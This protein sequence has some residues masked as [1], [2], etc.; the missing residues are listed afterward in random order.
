M[1]SLIEFESVLIG[2][3]IRDERYFAAIHKHMD[4]SFF[5]NA[6]Y[7]LTF[8]N[9]KNFYDKYERIPSAPEVALLNGRSGMSSLLEIVEETTGYD[10][11]GD[12]ILYEKTKTFLQEKNSMKALIEANSDY[13]ERKLDYGKVLARF[14]EIANIG[15]H[16]DF[17]IEL[18]AD[19]KKI[20]T[21]LRAEDKRIKTGWAWLDKALRGGWRADGKKL[22]L[23]QGAANVG[24]SIWLGNV[25]TN[26]CRQGKN[27]L[28]LSFEM[29]EV[30]YAERLLSDLTK[31]KIGELKNQGEGVISNRM[32]SLK[33]NTNIGSLYVKEFPPSSITVADIKVFITKLIASGRHIDAIVVDYIGLI[34]GK[35]GD[36]SYAKG[37]DVAEKL[38]ALSYVF[39][40]PVITATQI[41]RG[42]TKGYGSSAP[43]LDDV[44]DSLALVQ[45][46]D[47]IFGIWQE[48]NDVVLGN[49]NL[50]IIKSR[51]GKKGV[52][53]QFKIDYGTLT[54]LE[55]AYTM[56]YESNMSAADAFDK[57]AEKNVR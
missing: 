3:S 28:L 1:S 33:D 46:A 54:I 41:G 38:R 44:S 29:S 31:I 2:K 57:I 53:T 49:M 51:E 50:A 39:C 25:A 32:E 22:Y 9:L 34:K 13:K 10:E 5:T 37:K 30:L 19:A 16:E 12:D 17:G 24:K 27:V 36:N 35:E 21:A 14:E 15:F 52:K 55:D 43:E 48:E 20:E 47:E 4:S 40:V 6:A 23:F 18:F 8:E 26:I 7:K 56:Q 45:T 11:I 42:K